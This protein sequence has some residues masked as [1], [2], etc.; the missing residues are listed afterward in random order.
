ML[1]HQGMGFV[2]MFD[3]FRYNGYNWKEVLKF[4]NV[5]PNISLLLLS[6]PQP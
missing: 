2:K 4:W 6:L 5:G 1:C 3:Y